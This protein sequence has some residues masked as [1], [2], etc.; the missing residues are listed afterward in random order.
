MQNKQLI[1]LLED[2][3]LNEKEAT[4]YLTSLSLGP[5]SISKISS[6]SDIKRT[7]AYPI[8]DSLQQKGLI[9]IEVIGLKYLYVAQDPS[10]LESIFEERRER[11]KKLLPEFYA[12]QTLKGGESTIKYYEGIESVKNAYQEILD[13]LKNNDDYYVLSDAKRWHDIDPQFADKYL[14]KRSK[15]KL[16]SKIMYQDTEM[17]QKLKQSMEAIKILPKQMILNTSLIITSKKVIIHQLVAPISAV[18]IENKSMIQ[19]HKDMFE[20]IWDSIS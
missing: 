1:T 16:K 7:T 15:I 19:M 18:V 14:E 8:I 6:A 2:L 4:I 13:E 17:A 11:L 5:S 20:I 10:K 3:G 9:K 12:L